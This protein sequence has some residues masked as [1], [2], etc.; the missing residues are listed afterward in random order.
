MIN[1]VIL[2]GR[3]TADPEVTIIPASDKTSDKDIPVCNIYIAVDRPYSKKRE[4]KTDFI[5]VTI[6]NKMA[7]FVGKYFEKG[8]LIE[9]I[10]SL[11]ARKGK[12]KDDSTY[13]ETFVLA[14]EIHFA[15]K[16]AGKKSE[17]SSDDEQTEV[18]TIV[19]DNIMDDFDEIE[20]E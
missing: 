15:P 8:M 3:L 16:N 18:T 5:K 10:G 4:T 17:L 13:Y 9:V 2:T 6:K 12:R 19:D 1:E 11:R 20:V 14:K 7:E